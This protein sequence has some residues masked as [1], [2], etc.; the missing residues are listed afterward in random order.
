MLVRA[1]GGSAGVRA[2]SEAAGIGIAMP[3]GGNTSGKGA[4]GER[5][6]FHTCMHQVES[7]G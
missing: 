5:N 6:R 4:M 1:V 7:S 3:M 2:E